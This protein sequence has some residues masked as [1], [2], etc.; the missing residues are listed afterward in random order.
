MGKD[1]GLGH[2]LD[3][4]NFD[5]DT[6]LENGFEGIGDIT[7]DNENDDERDRGEGDGLDGD[8]GDDGL[9]G[10]GSDAGDGSENA[11]V[12]DDDNPVY[13]LASHWK[14]TGFLGTDQDIPKD[15]DPAGLEAIVKPNVIENI[16]KEFLAEVG[17]KLQLR[18]I[19]PIE[20]F[21][22]DSGL[23]EER[24][25]LT[26]YTNISK[27]EYSGIPVDKIDGILEA[28]GVEFWTSK[29]FPA[30]EAKELFDRDLE[31]V[32]EEEL[33][34]KYK[35]HFGVKANA[36]KQ[37]I[38]A[39][40]LAITEKSNAKAASDKAVI[41]SYIKD[42]KMSAEDEKKVYDG[43]YNKNQV[44]EEN[45]VR[46]RVTLA[47]K[48]RW[49]L[50]KDPAYLLSQDINLILGKDIKVIE[51][52]AEAKGKNSTLDGLAK[53]GA[54]RNRGPVNNKI[55]DEGMVNI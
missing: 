44:I 25:L 4:E 48:K 20:L 5:A 2:D 11:P 54:V 17:D 8:L 19:D 7:P 33:F 21:V 47:A 30:A 39:K 55:N 40:E 3:G 9:G 27:W 53:V 22:D 12:G 26:S 50:S 28:L 32:D 45:G 41:D 1:E 6:I 24:A 46:R 15:I 43:L 36:L 14:E 10:E 38:E 49:E 31:K 51:K 35:K 34:E 52:V 16:K 23:F 42:M 18:G 29:D 13:I 37:T